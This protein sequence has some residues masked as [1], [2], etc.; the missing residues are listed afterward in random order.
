MYKKRNN[1]ESF[2]FHFGEKYRAA[3]PVWVGKIPIEV[4]AIF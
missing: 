1:T 3:I 4:A 2:S